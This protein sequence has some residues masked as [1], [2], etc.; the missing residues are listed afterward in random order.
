MVRFNASFIDEPDLIFGNSLEEKDPRLGIK[1]G[2]PYFYPSEQG[3]EPLRVKVGIIGSVKTIEATNN[4]IDLLK[5]PIA[6]LQ[7]NKWLHPD[8]PGYSLNTNLKSEFATAESW[9]H[10]ISVQ[11]I[12]R[13]VS[14]VD[15]ND[16]IAAGVNLFRNGVKSISSEDD[17][18][19]VIICALPEEIEVYCGIS[20]K[21][22]GAKRPKFTEA[23]RQKAQLSSVG[24]VFLDKYSEA[25]SLVEDQKD[26]DYDFRNALKG[27]IMEFD[28]PI[29]ILRWTRLDAV[30]NFDTKKSILT[31]EPA[32]FAWNFSMG[33]YYKARG[34]PWRLAKLRQDTC[35]IGISFYVNKL[36]PNRNI[37]TSMAQ[38]FTHNGEGIVLR[39]TE[40]QRDESTY[41]AH[42]T[43]EQAKK[44]ISESLDRYEQKANRTPSRVVIHKTSHFSEEEIQGIQA[45]IGRAY[46]DLV[47]IKKNH[48]Y[49]FLRTGDYPVL[50]GTIISLNDTNFLLYTNGYVA[51]IRTYEGPRIPIPLLITQ[52]G[53]STQ[54]EISEEILGLTKLN[55]N[56]TKFATL[57]PITL[58]F[59]DKVGDVLSELPDNAPIKDHYRFYM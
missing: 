2:G 30:I 57:M 33:M 29:Q 5:N 28:I 58:E 4:L 7:P 6:S 51:R 48:P 8:F 26:L 11:E 16:R 22:R 14:I 13:V 52:I 21:T 38:V 31:Q 32:E 18:P 59:S 47:T 55:W 43:K 25:G 53:D 44:L 35:Y 46:L 39:G 41:E 54:K 56:T 20:T 49:R 24:Q 19:H 27:K 3:P 37:E 9:N 15:V 34:K 10:K 36:I 17:P 12:Q 45:S 40:V 50:R 23:E 1:Y 42:M